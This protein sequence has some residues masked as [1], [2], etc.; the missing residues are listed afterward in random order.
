MSQSEFDIFV[1]VS[2]GHFDALIKKCEELSTQYQFFGQIGSGY[3]T[4]SFPF[5]RVLP[6]KTLKETMAR[7]EVIIT[8]AG[9]GML[10]LCYEM[11]KRTVVVPKQRRYGEAN[12]GQV[13][14]GKRWCEIGL[15]IFCPDVNDLAA[16]IE[17]ARVLHVG[18]AEFPALGQRILSL[19]AVA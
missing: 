5:V 7:A 2:T 9:T 19:L 13:E 17:K 14:L 6:L 12:D 15:G 8:H 3:F 1:G 16:A 18:R 4:P 10:S 11:Q